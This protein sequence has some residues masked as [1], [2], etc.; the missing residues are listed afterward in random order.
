ME[1]FRVNYDIGCNQVG[2]YPAVWSSLGMD[3]FAPF[4]GN[5]RT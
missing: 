1:L 4:S 5:H 2:V 3:W